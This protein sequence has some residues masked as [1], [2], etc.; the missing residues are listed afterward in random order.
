MIEV[1]IAPRR[2][3]KIPGTQIKRVMAKGRLA[4]REAVLFAWINPKT[5]PAATIRAYKKTDHPAK[6][7]DP[8]S[9]INNIF[10]MGEI[11]QD[12]IWFICYNL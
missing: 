12:F 9:C 3:I 6:R 5:P 8:P 4:K 1:T 2:L 10:L 7:I 11:A